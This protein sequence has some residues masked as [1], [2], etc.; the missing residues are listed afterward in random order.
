MSK[1][2]LFFVLIFILTNITDVYS[3]EKSKDFWDITVTESL[4]NMGNLGEAFLT[5]RLDEVPKDTIDFRNTIIIGIDLENPDPTFKAKV[6]KYKSTEN[7][8]I[9]KIDF[10]SETIG[11]NNFIITLYDYENQRSIKL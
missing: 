11:K 1:T 5:I 10:S 8:E 9:Y 7:E 6:H 3:S 2:K 4:I